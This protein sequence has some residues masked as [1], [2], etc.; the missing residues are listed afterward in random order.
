MSG[1]GGTPKNFKPVSHSRQ[2]SVFDGS[3][4][5][6]INS[7]F[8]GLSSAKASPR[9]TVCETPESARRHSLQAACKLTSSPA[10]G[11]TPVLLPSK[12][13]HQTMCASPPWAFAVAASTNEGSAPSPT[14]SVAS[15]TLSTQSIHNSFAHVAVRQTPHPAPRNVL[16]CGMLGASTKVPCASSPVAY[17]GLRR[18]KSV[19]VLSDVL[20]KPIQV[21]RLLSIQAA[22]YQNNSHDRK[23]FVVSAKDPSHPVQL[24]SKKTQHNKFQEEQVAKKMSAE[25]SKPTKLRYSHRRTISVFEGVAH[26][27]EFEDQS[28]RAVSKESVAST[29]TPTNASRAASS[30]VSHASVA[31]VSDEEPGL[32]EQAVEP[33]TSS[34]ILPEE[35]NIQVSAKLSDQEIQNIFA[36]IDSTVSGSFSRLNFVSACISDFVV[37]KAM[38]PDLDCSQLLNDKVS[39]E[40]ADTLFQ[41]I[42]GCKPRV[43]LDMFSSYMKGLSE[44]DDSRFSTSQSLFE[45]IDANHDGTISKLELLN[46]V[47][48]FPE[49]ASFVLPYKHAIAEGVMVSQKMYQ[50]LDS[51]FKDMFCGKR[52][53]T[54]AEF[55]KYF[56]QSVPSTFGA[57]IADSDRTNKKVLI[58]EPGFVTNG[59]PDRLGCLTNAGFQ[60]RTVSSLPLE[61]GMKP[62][63]AALD[64]IKEAIE[65][66]KPNVIVSASFGSLHMLSLW[67]QGYWNGPS[68]V[69]NAHTSLAKLPERVKVV[70]AAGSN[71]EVHPRRREDLDT[72]ICTGSPN[73]TFLY[74]TGNSGR[75]PTGNFLRLGDRHSMDSLLRYDC[76]PRLIDAAT[77]NCS[78]ET[79]ILRSWA[80]RLSVERREAEAWL[81]YTP[82]SLRRFWSS[83]AASKG[84]CATSQ[85]KLVPLSTDCDEYRHVVTIFKA[86]PVE[87]PT[88]RSELSKAQWQSKKVLRVERVENPSRASLSIQPYF[89][90]I[91]RTVS[92]QGSEFEPGVHTHWAFHCAPSIEGVVT[93]PMSGVWEPV[94]GVPTP[95]GSGT[96]FAR[97]ARHAFQ[98]A[99][100][101]PPAFDGARRMILCL[102]T[103]GLSCLGSPSHNA[104]LPF[105]RKPYRYNSSVDSL[106]N[107]EV[108]VLQ[109]PNAAEAA[110]VITFV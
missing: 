96:Y 46:A 104:V 14:T 10:S 91:Y 16:S 68:V 29:S 48:R 24:P 12:A 72:L 8:S 58:I 3:T 38:L 93:D 47:Q 71:D 87:A 1:A 4:S 55:D 57:F 7:S 43:T 36:R 86:E 80:L 61:R 98:S 63:A 17:T 85:T 94:S 2:R 52:R 21:T 23:S 41:K 22:A 50:I 62:S 39:F 34:D 37:A 92:D 30:Q 77:D 60:I 107:P 5:S 106:S 51:I 83:P 89:N 84:R 28:P 67:E 88:L 73:H 79:S 97:D 54:F 99:H 100:C 20:A 59:S 11:K 6:G 64:L 56:N 44:V 90:A 75:Q 74:Y 45:K 18:T 81:G 101:G 27:P 66:F 109:H 53:L 33:T 69:I 15:P 65:S 110:Y 19:S 70:L 26:S 105:S 49:V 40:K 13:L 95:W 82:D 35:I 103:T 78:P 42:A 108:Y 102:L 25:T 31:S 76:L 32:G 9:L